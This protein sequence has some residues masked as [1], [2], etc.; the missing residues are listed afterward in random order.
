MDLKK[1][2][3]LVEEGKNIT[4]IAKACDITRKTLYDRA[5]KD[6]KLAALLAKVEKK[7]GSPE[8]PIDCED[9][10]KLAELGCTEYEI[11]RFVG[12]AARNFMKR[13]QKDPKIQEAI[14]IGSNDIKI[15]IRRAQLTVAMPKGEYHGNVTMLIWLGKQYLKQTD[16]PIDG[17][18]KDTESDGMIEALKATAKDDWK[19]ARP[20]Q[21]ATTEPEA[22]DGTQLDAA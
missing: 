2:A 3:R 16:N 4:A 8:I 11:A 6:P 20:V 15:A 10:R 13:K 19:D 9:V 17:A 21:M 1:V 18:D 5:K 12:I 7:H 22:A 14:D